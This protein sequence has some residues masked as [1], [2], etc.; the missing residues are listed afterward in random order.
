MDNYRGIY[1]DNNDNDNIKFYEGGAHFKYI[2]LVKKLEILYKEQNK[3][4]NRKVKSQECKNKII[5]SNK[6]Y[7]RNLINN[8]SSINY[9]KIQKEDNKINNRESQ[10]RNIKPLIQSLTQKLTIFTNSSKNKK[11]LFNTRNKLINKYKNINSQNSKDNIKNYYKKNI[12]NHP[13]F[14]LDTFKNYNKLNR[15][16]SVNIYL[17]KNKII[18]NKNIIHNSSCEIFDRNNLQNHMKFNCSN[19]DLNNDTSEINVSNINLSRNIN[20]LKTKKKYY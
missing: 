3:N 7:S 8:N 15:N 14:S 20:K 5:N 9:K 18:F 6:Q 13:D 16:N 11:K 17:N 10:S 1:A 2:N 12:I 4:E 19:N